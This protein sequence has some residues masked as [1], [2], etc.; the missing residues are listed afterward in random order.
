MR[1]EREE[2]KEDKWEKEKKKTFSYDM[3]YGIIKRINI[4]K[5]I[6]DKQYYKNRTNGARSEVR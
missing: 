2:D 4:W 6:T 3:K 5:N 1:S